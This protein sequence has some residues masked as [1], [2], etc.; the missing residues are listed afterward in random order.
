MKK[1]LLHDKLIVRFVSLFGLGL[2][3]FFL[4][5]TL[6]YIALPEG[7]LRGRLAAGALAGEA[8]AASFL[9]E[10]LRIFA[11]NVTIAAVFVFLANRILQVN[12]Y[13]LGY[14]P[15]LIYFVFYAV[16]L[17]TN[18]FAI[19]LAEPLAPSLQVLGRSG[20]YELAAYILVA[21]SSYNIATAK[22]RR[23][24][25]PDSEPVAPK[26]SL[27]RNTNWIGIG[28]AVLV[29]GASNAWEAYQI[30]QL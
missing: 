30:M 5:W 1:L 21:T 17:G 15:P 23:F 8:A 3:L 28:L 9:I 24:F 6:S 16:L 14:L 19:P 27:W 25:P 26:P 2:V 12:D 13:P 10:F 22:A 18:S 11:L 20:L 7:F 4:V 29:L